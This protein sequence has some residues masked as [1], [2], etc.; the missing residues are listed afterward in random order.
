M[1]MTPASEH[2]NNVASQRIAKMVRLLFQN[3]ES[4]NKPRRGEVLL[5]FDGDV[6]QLQLIPSIIDNGAVRIQ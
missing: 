2:M 1:V 3:E 4:I 5:K 6:V